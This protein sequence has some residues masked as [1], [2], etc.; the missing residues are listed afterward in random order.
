MA[1][2]KSSILGAKAEILESTRIHGDFELENE[3]M[4]FAELVEVLLKNDIDNE[5]I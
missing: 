1:L 5:D 2:S 4:E 3:S